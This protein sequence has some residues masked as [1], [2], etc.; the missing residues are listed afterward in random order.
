MVI[1]SQWDLS[2][3]SEKT[4]QLC[5]LG[6]SSEAGGENMLPTSHLSYFSFEYKSNVS[7]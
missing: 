6:D 1:P 2:A 7:K 3:E 4:N 5:V